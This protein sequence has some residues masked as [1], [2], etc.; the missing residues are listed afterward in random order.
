MELRLAFN[1]DAANYDRWRPNYVPE[2]FRQIIDYSHLNGTG[3]VLEIGIGTGQATLP[4]LR[5]GCH[6]TAIEIGEKLAD[7]TRRKFG[8]FSNLN[9]V[10]G[11][12]E[13]FNVQSGTYDLILSA[14]AF[15]WIPEETGYPKVFDLLKKSGTLALFWNHPHVNRQDD[16]LHA[17]IRK[18]YQKYRPSDKDPGEFNESHCQKIVDKLS[19]YGFKNITSKLFYQTRTLL[20]QDY[21]ALLNTYSDHRTLQE[22][23]KSSLEQEILSAID[24]FGGK[25]NIYDTIDLYLAQT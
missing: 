2:L 15:H 20:A 1:E 18:I 17:K 4:I 7:Y 16:E 12:F 24:Q 8:E 22:S 19:Y 23:T 3:E 9:V 25:L 21:I 13:S 11:E 6:V 10:H 5:T 14:T